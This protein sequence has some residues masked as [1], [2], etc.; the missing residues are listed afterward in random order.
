MRVIQDSDDEFQ[1]DLPDE[2]H[3]APARD[4][5]RHGGKDVSVESGS[6]STE[7]LKR[8]FAEAQR[9]HLHSPSTCDVFASQDEPQSSVSLPAHVSKRMRTLHDGSQH[10]FSP[11]DSPHRGPVFSGK[12][13]T[14]T[15]SS[16]FLQLVD[17]ETAADSP[18]LEGTNRNGYFQHNPMALFP[19]D[20]SSTIPN[21]T[22]TQ[23]RIL[24]GVRAPAL[25]GIESEHDLPPS[26]RLDIGGS[27]PWSDLLNFTPTGTG[28]QPETSAQRASDEEDL[29]PTSHCVAEKQNSQ[30]SRHGPSTNPRG[31]PLRNE[32]VPHSVDSRDGM[33]PPQLTLPTQDLELPSTASR[34]SQFDEKEQSQNSSKRQVHGLAPMPDSEDEL[35]ALDLPVEQYKPRPSR[36]RSLKLNTVEHVDYSIRPEKA[37]KGNKRRKTTDSPAKTPAPMAEYIT[38]PEKV[39]QICDMGF[40]PCSTGKALKQ[41]NGD[42]MVTVDYLI[43]NGL[44]EDE[45]ASNN[46]SQRKPVKS[47]I[48]SAV[49]QPSP[50][51]QPGAS[52]LVGIREPHV[53]SATPIKPSPMEDSKNTI[54]LAED[55]FSNQQKSPKVQVVIPTNPPQSKPSASIASSK[56]VK[57]RKTTSDLPDPEK[58]GD[59]MDQPEVTTEKKRGRGRP[60]KTSNT[61]STTELVQKAQGD[62]QPEHANIESAVLQTI[63]SNATVTPIASISPDLSAPADVQHTTL[64]A[65]MNSKE[66][67]DTKTSTPAVP[68]RTSE[69]ATK[70]SSR[71][72]ASKG[73]ALYRVGLSKRARIAPLLR[74]LKK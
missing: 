24:E 15:S 21:T 62:V 9:D 67:D 61:V 2:V 53:S 74:T 56:R 26:H 41:N 17:K 64:T 63:E 59:T 36:S 50:E 20:P 55:S 45:L 27:V 6:G 52:Q 8:A 73:K 39:R 48:S 11:M 44:D 38:T 60:K 66:L 5:S 22:Q 29:A 71:S 57:R 37:A 40:T 65:A 32:V 19:D 4:A 69:Q 14:A 51:R 70:S 35:A 54:D 1:D 28:E 25:L 43:T 31:S 58:G 16:P 46:P 34:A 49:K 18:A 13:G 33:P 12:E 47:S 68:A 7:S 3:A 42:V 72:P 30:Q 23:R 10:G